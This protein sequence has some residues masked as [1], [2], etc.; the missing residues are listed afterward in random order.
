MPIHVGGT[1]IGARTIFVAL[2]ASMGGFLFGYD[3]GQISGIQEMPRFIEAFSTEP[4]PRVSRASRA[5][6]SLA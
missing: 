4:G 5:L 2:L 1:P 3:S 6:Q